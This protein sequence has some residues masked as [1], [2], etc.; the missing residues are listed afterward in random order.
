MR[1]HALL[2]L[3]VGCFIAAKPE[4]DKDPA[5]LEG[6]WVTSS[7]EVGGNKAPD[8]ELK[9]SPGRLTLKGGKWTFTVGGRD[10]NGTFTADPA[11]RP[12]QMDLKRSDGPN[13]G[14]TIRVIYELNGDTLKVCYAP[15][16]KER[17]T[18]FDTTD[19]PGYAL[20]VYRREKPSK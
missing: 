17:P 7:L 16:G 2:A 13:A 1:R 3:A 15:L 9:K 20:I 18:T 19:K 5:K 10:Q 14:K 8:A 11:K 4:G 6:A 12:A